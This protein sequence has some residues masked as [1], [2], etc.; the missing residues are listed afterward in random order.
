MSELTVNLIGA[1]R[2]GQ[3]LLG[4]L[5]KAP[6]CIVQDVLSNSYTSAENAVKFAGAGRAV[7][8]CTEL[9]PADLWILAVPDTQIAVVAD[10]LA[11][12]LPKWDSGQLAPVAFHCSGFFA[13]EQMAP[14]RKLGWHLASVHPVLTFATP[15]LALR[16]FNGV[17]CGVEGDAAAL[18]VVNPLLES[19]GAKP[20]SIK[21]ESKSLYHAAAVISNNFTVVLQAIAREAWAE[22]GV[23]A[24]IAEQLNDS[25]LRATYENVSMEG[26]Q[27]AL[28]GPAAR[29]DD[30]VVQKQG[31]D[32][33]NWSLEVGTIYKE[34]SVLARR[35]KSTGEVLGPESSAE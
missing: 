31:E 17:H 35:L 27:K 8:D 3:T 4:L 1:G 21:S 15:E 30:F 18:E 7:R 33:A 14:L 26:P 5:S 10:R 23:P 6:D 25:M 24:D 2:V 11:E 32:V 29:G 9:H 22:A 19:L 13:A 16:Q 34:M 20:F 28:T 12:V